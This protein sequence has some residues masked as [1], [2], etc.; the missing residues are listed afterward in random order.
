MAMV[1]EQEWEMDCADVSLRFGLRLR[2]LREER[3]MTQARMATQFGVDWML[4]SD[5]E[6]GRR[7]VT[8]LTLY[9]MASGFGMSLSEL[10]DGL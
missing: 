6:E 2:A 5:V 4:V 10:V 1:D 8:V 7:E 9:V 3:G